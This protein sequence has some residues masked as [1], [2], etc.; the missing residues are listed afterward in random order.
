MPRE[1]LKLSKECSH[2]SY[3]VHPVNPREENREIENE[4]TILSPRYL[5]RRTFKLN[6]YC[7]T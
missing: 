7:T 3:V 5:D 2:D 6:I 1:R 4:T